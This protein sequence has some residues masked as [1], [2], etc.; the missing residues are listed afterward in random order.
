VTEGLLIP[1]PPSSLRRLAEDNGQYG[2][3]GAVGTAYAQEFLAPA[4][5]LP[6]CPMPLWHDD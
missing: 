5:R 4:G 1:L 2:T 6:A 3:R